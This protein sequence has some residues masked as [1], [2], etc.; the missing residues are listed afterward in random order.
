MDNGNKVIMKNGLLSLSD[1]LEFT[2]KTGFDETSPAPYTYALDLMGYSVDEFTFQ[3]F[4]GF[5]YH[6]KIVRRVGSGEIKVYY[7]GSVPGMGIHVVISS[8]CMDD[9]LKHYRDAHS[10]ATPFSDSAYEMADLDSDVFLDFLAMICEFG[11]VTRLDIAI[12]DIGAC[13]FTVPEVNQY[14][15][16][17]QYSSR[18]RHTEYLCS[19]DNGAVSGDTVYVGK[20]TSDFMLRVYDKQAEQN[21]KRASQELPLIETPW[22][23]WEMELKGDSA[24]RACE[25]LLSRKSLAAVGVGILAQKIRLIHLDNV[26]KARCS[27]LEKWND[28]L[29]N[30]EKISLYHR[31]PAPAVDRV[32]A[33]LKRQVAPSLAAVV[34]AFGGSVDFIYDLLSSGSGRL[35]EKHRNMIQ[36]Y[37]GVQPA[38]V[39]V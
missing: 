30:A 8:S 5:G 34:A 16:S 25:E 6:E 32:C 12:D 36:T 22:V 31:P 2:L 9:V 7:H 4:G 35:S 39:M 29:S 13:Y 37:W 23:R 24:V 10:S 15:E 14:I 33:W 11:S 3:P 17:G 21:R 26:R 19:R 1:W 28:F 38:G 18:I 27:T 20:R